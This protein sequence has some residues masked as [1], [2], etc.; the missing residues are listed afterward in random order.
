M[1]I[2]PSDFKIIIRP[3][4]PTESVLKDVW[5]YRHLFYF[6]A[7]RD[8]LVRYKQTL[9]G[10]AWGVIKPLSTMVVFTIVF[11][12]LADLPSGQVPYGVM[13]LAAL[14]PWQLFTN[15]LS[16]A[17]NSLLS[18]ASLVS[19]VYFP[20]MIIPMAAVVVA[21]ADFLIAFALLVGMMLVYG[22]RPG[23]T[24]LL[25]PGFMG[26]AVLFSLGAGLFI[27][28]LNV[29]FRDFMHLMPFVLQFGLYLSPVGYSSSI[30]PDGWR[31]IY[32]LN[33]MV[34]VIDGFRWVLLGKTAP[35]FW[36]GVFISAALSLL[37]FIFGFKFFIRN[38]REFADLI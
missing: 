10:V 7:W 21:L 31:F 9:V 1:K 3:D 4:A 18:N 25:L 16:G 32:S 12:K 8:I 15:I 29:K 27:A 23:I 11:G 14:L 28:A 22:V 30:V 37:I 19:K 24:I 35:V 38:E 2:D 36:P 26:I 17:G 20:R 34:G 33:P 13:V 6:L 5:E